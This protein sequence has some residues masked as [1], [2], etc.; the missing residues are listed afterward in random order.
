MNAQRSGFASKI[1]GEKKAIR[2][3][4]IRVWILGGG[5]GGRGRHDGDNLHKSKYDIDS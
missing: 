5:G 1:S 3:C 2:K 4:A